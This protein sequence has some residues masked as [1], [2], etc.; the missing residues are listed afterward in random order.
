MRKII[1]GLKQ[2]C[3]QKQSEVIYGDWSLIELKFKVVN[4]NNKIFIV[5]KGK[6]NAK[7]KL[8]LDDLLICEKN[9]MVY[10]NISE[11]GLQVLFKNN[12]EIKIRK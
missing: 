12:H 3:C 5:S 4:S 2:L 8:Y 9:S 10:K 11:N 1:N 7:E 6:E